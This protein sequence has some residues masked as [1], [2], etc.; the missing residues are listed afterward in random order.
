MRQLII[1]TETTGLDPKQGH[2]IIEIAARRARRPPR[3]R[4]GTL[5]FHLDPGARDRLRRDRGARHDVGRSAG[6]AALPRRRRRVRRVRARRR[7]DHPQRAVRRRV[8]RRRV[9][10]SRAC[11]AARRCTATLVDTLALARETFP[12]KRNNLDALCERFGVYNAHRTL[13]GALLD[14]QLLAEVY[15]AMTR[16]QESLTI[17]MRR[18]AAIAGGRAGAVAAGDRAARCV[19]IAADRRRSSP[20]TAAYLEALD[21]ES[22]GRCV[23]LALE[24]DAGRVA[25]RAEPPALEPRRGRPA[26]SLRTSVTRCRHRRATRRLPIRRRVRAAL[27]S[28]CAR[29]EPRTRSIRRRSTASCRCSRSTGA[30]WRW[31]QDA[32]VPLLERLRFLCIVGSNL[33]EF[34]EIRVAG[35]QGTAARE[36]AAARHD[37]ARGARRCSRDVGDEARALIADQY[38]VLNDAGAAGA[39]RR[40]RAP[41][42]AAPSSRRASAR[43]W[44]DYFRARCGRC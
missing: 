9:R 11:R 36:G 27:P 18:G 10:A 13:H 40:R 30:C 16:G 1:D 12:G 6:Q 33:D 42:P 8:P 35:L 43:G 21:R 7:V 23:W 2:R 25:R 17:D 24:R 19:V 38:R 3:R 31:P 26:R 28:R 32:R 22:R 37:A 41:P 4:A 39:R 34:F 29:A 44:R 14:A 15:L 5:H 20:R